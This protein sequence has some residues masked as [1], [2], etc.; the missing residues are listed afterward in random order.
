MAN[1][2]TGLFS[3][4]VFQFGNKELFIQISL[5]R[6]KKQGNGLDQNQKLRPLIVTLIPTSLLMCFCDCPTYLNHLV[7]LYLVKQP[8]F[9]VL[10]KIP[11]LY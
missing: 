7:I 9:S 8:N 10:L 4:S 5:L 1:Y 6:H 2:V 11:Y 3:G